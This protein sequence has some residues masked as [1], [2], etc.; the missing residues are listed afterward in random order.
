[1]VNT[2]RRL[3]GQED[4]SEENDLFSSII[5]QPNLFIQFIIRAIEFFRVTGDSLT[6]RTT[7]LIPPISQCSWLPQPDTQSMHDPT[8]RPVRKGWE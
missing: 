1:M 7:P 3:S 5:G 8:H 4:C 6:T 2:S